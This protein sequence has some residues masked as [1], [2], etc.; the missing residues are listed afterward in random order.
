[1][2]A[3]IVLLICGLA[4]VLAEVFFPSLGLLAVTAAAC[5]LIAD[6]MAFD[7]GG[8]FLGWTFIALEVF[9]IPFTVRLAFLWLPK[10]SFGKRML[11]A[12]PDDV[13]A[14]LP[15]LAHLLGQQGQAETDLRPSGRAA[16]GAQHH[17]VL[18]RSGVIPAGAAVIVVA[19]EG[20]EIQVRALDDQSDGEPT[21][22]S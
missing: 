20:S 6:I 10:L 2:I 18:A 21:K 11:L 5:F 13:G 14:G 15:D 1:M 9:M 17:S 16:F 19:I 8:Q 12:Q 22:E 3:A 4:F 7:S